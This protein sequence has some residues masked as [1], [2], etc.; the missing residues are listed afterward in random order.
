MAVLV[1]PQCS[2]LEVASVLDPMR[3]A[4]RH[5]GQEALSLARRVAGRRGG[6]ADLRASNCPSSGALEAAEGADVLAVIAGYRQSE[7]ATRPLMRD[8]RPHG[9]RFRADRGGGCGQLGLARAGL[10]DGHRATVHW[11]D[12]EDFAAAHPR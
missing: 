4:N 8:L 9:P 10:L 3:A 11:E 5:L 6:A 12:L 2:I 7:V 1:L